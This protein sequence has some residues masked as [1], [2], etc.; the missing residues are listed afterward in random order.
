MSHFFFSV[1]NQDDETDISRQWAGPFVSWETTKEKTFLIQMV[2]QPI[3]EAE[4]FSLWL[5][6]RICQS[7]WGGQG[8]EAGAKKTAL[9]YAQQKICTM[10]FK[11]WKLTVCDWQLQRGRIL[12][13]RLTISSIKAAFE[14]FSHLSA[15]LGLLLI[16][17]H[18]HNRNQSAYLMP[19]A[20]G[21]LHFLP[22]TVVPAN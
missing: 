17:S 12:I 16:Q 20:Y 8:W 19:Y 22:S 2:I 5:W 4:V 18:H 7:L 21:S 15:N 11:S 13:S 10:H 6:F 9:N 1:L 3:L 14:I